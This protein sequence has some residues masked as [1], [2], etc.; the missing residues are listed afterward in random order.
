M[1]SY[2][3]VAGQKYKDYW[4]LIH[5]P[6]V[7]DW[8]AT[9]AQRVYRSWRTMGS[10]GGAIEFDSSMWYSRSAKVITVGPFTPGRRGV[11]RPTLSGEFY[12]Y[13]PTM[14]DG[15]QPRK[16]FTALLDSMTPTLAWIVGDARDG[17]VAAFTAKDH[18]FTAGQPLRKRI[19]LLNDTRQEQPYHCTWQVVLGGK[20]IAS[21]K[22]SGTLKIAQTYFAPVICRL[23][24]TLTANKVEGDISIRA[25][26]GEATHEDHFAFRV[27]TPVQP[28]KA[29]TVAV[30]DPV[31]HTT[32]MLK[33]L[34]YQ[35]Q[36]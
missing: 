29:Q 33:H 14:A 19:A 10:T 24:T 30:I 25:T 34:G 8:L 18:S 15:L 9:S 27:F 23:P 22:D 4:G 26:I 21:G 13:Q 17:D 32:A 7:D 3:F 12:S 36:P 2:G 11:Y 31:G 35:V 5:D 16:E 28:A 20:V 1:T 6:C